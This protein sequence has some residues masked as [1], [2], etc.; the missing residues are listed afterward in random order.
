MFEA[1]VSGRIRLTY[2]RNRK[3]SKYL[4]DLSVMIVGLLEVIRFGD[5]EVHEEQKR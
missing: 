3:I 2:E 5:H 4:N 1:T